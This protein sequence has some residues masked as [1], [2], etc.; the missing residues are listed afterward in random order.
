VA[1][2][3]TSLTPVSGSITFYGRGYGHGVGMSQYGAR[4]RALAGQDVATILAH[5]YQGTSLSTIDPET[6]IRVRV[7]SG[8][9][10]ASDRPLV[11]YGRKAPW[12]IDGID[13][14]FPADARLTLRPTIATIDGAT[15]VS[16]RLQVEDSGSI[17]LERPM[18]HSF[19]VR[20][21]MVGGR[22]ELSSKPSSFDT[23][24]RVLRVFPKS[25]APTVTVVNELKLETYLRGVVP[26]EMPSTWPAT[27]L[28]A[29]AVVARSF[30]A[31]RLRPG[32]GK[33]DVGDDTSWQVYHGSLAER[34]SA[35]DAIATTAGQVV[36]SG[37]SIAN[38]LYHSTGGAATENNEDV[39]VSA[40]GDPAASPVS[41]LRGSSDRDPEGTSYDA[42]SPYATWQTAT[43]T[44]TQLSSWLATD[45]RTSV[46][47]LTGIDLSDRGVS[48]R[49]ISIKLVG[50]KATRTVSANLLRSVFNAN[51]PTGDPS[52]RSTLFYLT[53]LS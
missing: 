38:T 34:S 21:T 40:S 20:P 23:Y 31:V 36:M 30:A 16:W 1:D 9:K 29:Q 2:A 10:A 11:I 8:W 35:T 14:T 26:A 39:F 5:Y 17:V 27:A 49:L 41:Y 37:S 44:I 47:T 32:V 53:P 12:T 46:G 22:V 24:R 15:S 51:R 43:Y 18:N 13:A 45:S 4:G 3:S 19:R 6:P 42:G 52:L 28:E 33:Y 48:G 50:T 7:L 25:T